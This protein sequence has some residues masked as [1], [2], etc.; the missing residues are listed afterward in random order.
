MTEQAIHDAILRKDPEAFLRR[1]MKM[2]NPG[3]PYQPNWHI[4]ALE[5]QL[6]R[7]RRGEIKRLMISVPPRHL[8]STVVSVAFPAF[9]LGHDPTKRIIVVSCAL[10]LAVKHA[11]DFRAIVNSPWYKRAFP[12]MRVSRSKNTEYEVV[13][14]QGGYRL[15]ASID[16]GLTGRG[17]DIIIIDDPIN[18]PDAFSPRKRDRVNEWYRSTVPTRL[19]SKVSGAIIIVM[20]RWHVDDLCG[21]LLRSSENWCHLRLAAIAEA[22]ELIQIDDQEQHLRRAGEL[23]H[24]EREPKSALDDLRRDLGSEHFAAQY[25]QRPIPPTGA[26]IK[27]EWV[28]RYDKLP[29]RS[30]SSYVLQSWD[31]AT[32]AGAEH[33]FSACTTWLVHQ[34]GYYL[35]DVLRGRFDFPTLK[36]RAIAHA[37][38]HR[39]NKILIEDAA[40][41]QALADELKRAGLPAITVRPEG[42]KLTRMSIQSIKFENGLV[43]LPRE[44]PGLAEF[45]DELFAFPEAPHD[46]QVDSAS[47]ALA[48]KG[49]AFPWDEKALAGLS[50][51]VWGF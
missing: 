6:E 23:L 40:V 28:K 27:R 31:T 25:Q 19:N 13:T 43:L 16:A 38:K 36:A 32:K 50:K 48:N 51:F 33:S 12:V 26:M 17:G 2:L 47:Q 29:V 34:G 20:Q 42:D 10:D 15:A 4:Q 22:D 49:R 18:T 30:A 8:K 7:V 11:N 45:E 14:T 9:V 44:A 1:C 3:D 37:Q 41:G 39:P 24:P 5:Y 21:N 35:I 46:D